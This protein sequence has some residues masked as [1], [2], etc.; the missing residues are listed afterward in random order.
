MPL[1]KPEEFILLPCPNRALHQCWVAPYRFRYG[2]LLIYKPPFYSTEQSFPFIGIQE[3]DRNPL[4]HILLAL[5]L[6]PPEVADGDVR[7]YTWQLPVLTV[8]AGFPCI[9]VIEEEPPYPLIVRLVVKRLLPIL[10]IYMRR[11][12]LP[13]PCLVLQPY[14]AHL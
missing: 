4:E 1:Q 8:V 11:K 9:Q 7:C 6:Y 10:E 3:H 14:L 5:P 12:A 2:M 13:S